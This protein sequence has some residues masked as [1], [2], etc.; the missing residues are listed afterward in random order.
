MFQRDFKDVSRQK[1]SSEFSPWRAIPQHFSS[2]YTNKPGTSA[3]IKEQFWERFEPNSEKKTLG[4]KE[5]VGECIVASSENETS[6]HKDL[7]EERFDARL[8][9][10]TS[11]DEDPIEEDFDARSVNN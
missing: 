6:R 9:N 5:L 2:T 7:F 10:E 4:D 1:R 8:K 3:E 11:E